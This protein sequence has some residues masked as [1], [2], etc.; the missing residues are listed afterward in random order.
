[1]F[2]VSWHHFNGKWL[3]ALKHIFIFIFFIS[4]R[5][6]FRAIFH[7][8]LQRANPLFF[9]S[10]QRNS[11]EKQSKKNTSLSHAFTAESQ[12]CP[13]NQTDPFSILQKAIQIHSFSTFSLH[14]AVLYYAHSS[15]S[16]SR[17]Y[18]C[19]LIVI[20]VYKALSSK[21]SY[22]HSWLPTMLAKDDDFILLL[23]NCC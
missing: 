21:I 22:Y 6:S 18:S 7:I 14:Q 2:S 9:F 4:L 11:L 16:F 1:M 19:P 23:I 20:M 5:V 17:K 12:S 15:C 8:H 3:K 10:S 13:V